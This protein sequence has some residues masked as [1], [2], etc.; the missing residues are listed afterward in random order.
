MGCLLSSAFVVSFRCHLLLWTWAVWVTG[1]LEVTGRAFCNWQ[2]IGDQ[3]V[4]IILESLS[5][6]VPSV[7]ILKLLPAKL[8]NVICV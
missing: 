5:C 3:S 8:E 1:V 6:C 4:V 2:G 7:I